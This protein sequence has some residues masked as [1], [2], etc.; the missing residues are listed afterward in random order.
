MGLS[1]FISRTGTAAAVGFCLRRFM[2]LP[3][4]PSFRHFVISG[5]DVKLA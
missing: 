5:D 3:H 4:D 1:G 2:I